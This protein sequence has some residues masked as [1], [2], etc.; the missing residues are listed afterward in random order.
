MNTEHISP[1]SDIEPGAPPIR[2]TDDFHISSHSF[3]FFTVSKYGN[4]SMTSWPRE[5]HLHFL[6]EYIN[7]PITN[8]LKF[9]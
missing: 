3:M 5:C 1:P 2:D 9:E 4:E 7:C 6:R 8:I